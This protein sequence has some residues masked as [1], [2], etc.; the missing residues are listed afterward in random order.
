VTYLKIINW[1]EYSEILKK[2]Y[3]DLKFKQFQNIIAIGRGGSFIAAYLASKLGIPTFYPVFLRHVGLIETRTIDDIPP[4]VRD[5][6]KS[7]TGNLLIVDD[8]LREG[9]AMK[10][11]LDLIS[12]EATVETLVLYKRKD[13]EFETDIV[14]KYIEDTEISFPYDVLG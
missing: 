11:I 3:E 5:Q 8:Y 4:H 6:I 12:K 9:L 1:N 2:V 13:S 14:G 7:F 10:Y